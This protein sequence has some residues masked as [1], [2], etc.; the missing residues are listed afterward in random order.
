MSEEKEK[1]LVLKLI[2]FSGKVGRFFIQ[3][4]GNDLLWKKVRYKIQTKTKQNVH[5]LRCQKS[6]L[7]PKK[8]IK[9]L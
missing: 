4:L 9:T 5:C 3:Y 6:K 8:P 1:G 7:S 2:R